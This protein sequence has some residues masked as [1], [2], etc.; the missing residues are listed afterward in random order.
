ME[1][2]PYKIVF[3][4]PY[5]HPCAGQGISFVFYSVLYYN[6]D[7]FKDSFLW[8]T[9]ELV[10]PS[11]CSEGDGKILKDHQNSSAALFQ[12]VVVP[13]QIKVPPKLWTLPQPRDCSTTG[14]GLT[15]FAGAC[16]KPECKTR[17]SWQRKLPHCRNSITDQLPP[18]LLH[19]ALCVAV[20]KWAA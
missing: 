12:I 7:M 13:E 10:C 14:H 2:L 9:G 6:H 18:T 19:Y 16:T 15:G 3:W 8:T 4:I 20:S 5:A 17:S 1:N 11:V